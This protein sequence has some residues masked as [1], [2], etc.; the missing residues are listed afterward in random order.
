[1]P[2][3][4]SEGNIGG[5]CKAKVRRGVRHVSDKS[6]TSRQ[7]VANISPTSRQH[8]A[9]KCRT[10]MSM[11]SFLFSL[12]ILMSSFSTSIGPQEPPTGKKWKFEKKPSWADEF[13]GK[14]LPD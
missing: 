12:I 7:H 2:C 3:M 5:T 14:G 4:R 6:P 9:N 11:S 13:N 10:R 1:M 8:I